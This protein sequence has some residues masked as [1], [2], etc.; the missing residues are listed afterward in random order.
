MNRLKRPLLWAALLAII[1]LTAL[2]IYGAFLGADR[3]QGFFNALPA[4][5]YWF[6][7]A[8]LL[9][10]GFLVFPRIRVRS[11]LLTHLGCI[12]ILAGGMWGSAGGQRL[13]ARLLGREQI[14]KGQMPILEGTAENRVRIDGSDETPELPFSIRLRDFRMEYYPAGTVFIQN[15]AGMSWKLRGEPG[16][17]VSLGSDLGQVTVQRTFRNFKMSLEGDERVATDAPGDGNPAV[18]VLVTKP[19]GTK[20]TRYV[21]ANFPGHSRAGDP[22]TMSYQQMVRDYVSDLEVVEEGRVV[23]QKDIEVNHPLYYGGYHFYQHS[24]GQNEFGDYTIL[25]VVSDSGLTVVFTGYGLLSMGVC[26][27]FW[28]RRLLTAWRNRIAT[29]T[30]APE[31]GDADGR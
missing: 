28:F 19:D 10:A 20:S 26:W 21:F 29:G 18:E 30:V 17:T 23:K 14:H 31:Q 8:A 6:T 22:L 3:A 24:Y 2:A 15:R 16:E 13:Q 12:L 7:L 5:V 9:I 25:M 27:H 11:L 1:L 4:T